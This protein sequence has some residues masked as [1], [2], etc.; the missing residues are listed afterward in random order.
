MTMSLSDAI[1]IAKKNNYAIIGG[2][3]YDESPSSAGVHYTTTPGPGDT[4]SDYALTPDNAPVHTTSTLGPDAAGQEHSPYAMASNSSYKRK[5][6][7]ARASYTRKERDFD[8]E[9]FAMR[10]FRPS[11]KTY[12]RP[13]Y[14]APEAYV[15]PEYTAPEAFQRAEY[16]APEAFQKQ[17]FQTSAL[18]DDYLKKMQDVE[19]QQPGAYDSKYEGAIQSILDGILNNKGPYNIKDDINYNLLYEQARE[20][21]MANGNRAMR[22]AMGNMQAQ[23]GGYGSTAAQ[24]A[25]S[26]AYDNYLTALNDQN[27]QLAQLAYEMWLRDRDNQYNQLN[28]AM[29][30]DES[31]YARYRDRYNDWLNN[32][33]YMAN[34]YQQAYANDRNAYQYDTSMDYGIWKDAADAAREQY[35]YENSFDYNNW[36]DQ[37]NRAREQYEYDTNFDYNNWLNQANQS[38]DQYQYGTNMDYNQWQYLNDLDWQKYQFD[39]TMDYNTWQYLNDMAERQYQYDTSMDFSEQQDSDDRDWQEY[40]YDEGMDYQMSRDEINDYDNALTKAL[41]WAQAGRQVPV[42]YAKYL[43]DDTMAQLNA[44]SAQAVAAQAGIGGGS[45]GSRS[46]SSSGKDDGKE[47]ITWFDFVG[48]AAKISEDAY[49]DAINKGKTAKQAQ[50]AAKKEE[51]DF[52]KYV[53]DRYNVAWDAKKK[54][55]K[56][57]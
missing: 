34:Q 39:N 9:P 43:D 7:P 23:T 35:E 11:Q 33:N 27:P 38:W 6:R 44:L 12:V 22:D 21:A 4:V 45:S 24:T 28:A 36:L 42:Q 57:R 2:G 49:A 55:S 50:S 17:A 14:E 20:S 10:T 41:Q 32:R 46:R 5:S 51:K 31:D 3:N 30:V 53:K 15:R 26:Q 13:E 37:A 1:K 40:T 48:D 54:K 52:S 29:G 16:T 18:T 56:A 25:G 19:S 8:I 47:T